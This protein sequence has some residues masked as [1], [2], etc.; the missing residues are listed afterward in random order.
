[1]IL[2]R[3]DKKIL[4]KVHA[5]LI[6]EVERL[7][8]KWHSILKDQ[9]LLIAGNY[10]LKILPL[11]YSKTYAFN[12]EWSEGFGVALINWVNKNNSV[13]IYVE[14]DDD[15][16]ILDAFITIQY[17]STIQRMTNEE[18]SRIKSEMENGANKAVAPN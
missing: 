12:A 18:E 9:P 7:I 13:W 4:F 5:D 14:N 3:F 15:I 8:I 11:T 10:A 1:M 2:Q 17:Y 6:D 16:K